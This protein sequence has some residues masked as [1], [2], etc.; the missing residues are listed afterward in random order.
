MRGTQVRRYRPGAVPSEVTL[1]LLDWLRREFGAVAEG[2][3]G[4]WQ[5]PIRATPPERATEGML[6]YADGTLW[7]P[8]AGKGVYVYNGTAWIKL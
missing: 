7:N 6:V 1:G 8:G 3:E 5:L 2:F 4:Q